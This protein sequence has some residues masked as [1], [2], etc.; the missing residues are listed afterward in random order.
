MKNI[1]SVTTKLLLAFCFIV[2]VFG[3]NQRNGDSLPNKSD[4]NVDFSNRKIIY[5][6]SYH[7][8]YVP[9]G[10]GRAEFEKIVS[11]HKIK[12]KYLYLDAK[13][14]KDTAALA[15][16][17]RAMRDIIQEWNPD[18]IVAADDAVNKY[19][20][21]RFFLNSKIPVVF[22]GVNWS[23]EKYGY[24][25]KNITGQIE[26]D[27]IERLIKELQQFSSGKRIGIL[28]G[29]TLT[30]KKNIKHYKNI[31]GITFDKEVLVDTFSQWEE[32]FYSLQKS[33]DILILRHSAG[34]VGW[35]Q[36]RAMEIVRAGTTIPT[37]SISHIMRDLVLFTLPKMNEEY[38]EYAAKTAIRIL[39]G[40]APKDIPLSKN[41]KSFRAI[42]MTL[43]EKLGI[44]FPVDALEDAHFITIPQKKI[45][46][47]NSYHTGY[48]WSD[49][50][51]KG[52]LKA[53]NLTPKT[54]K[55]YYSGGKIELKIVRMNTKMN[56]GIEFKKDAALKV[57][58]TINNWNPDIIISADDNAAKYVI[59]PY[60][61]DSKI[62]IIF[63]GLNWD[64]SVYGFPTDNIRGMVEV[65]PVKELIEFLKKYS[66][67][68]R[69]GYLIGDVL[70]ERK[71][72]Q[73]YKD[74]LGINFH[75]GRSAKTMEEWKRGFLELQDSVDMIVLQNVAGIHGWDSTAIDSFVKEKIKVP[76]GTTS[77]TVHYLSLV[78]FSRIGEEQG[79]WSGKQV[80][81]ILNGK[82]IS[83]VPLVFN[84]EFITYYNMPLAKKLNVKLPADMMDKAI[85]LNK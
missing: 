29:N 67:G 24:P 23:V 14:V 49:D 66:K 30:D 59:V 41:V 15:A 85:I 32:S 35:N 43:A 73:H 5:I 62:P 46:F 13:R 19:V 40:T 8:E 81:E 7:E 82:P 52:L 3:C 50:I 53:L 54:G 75:N 16:K 51:E 10:K 83:D 11:Y 64:A 37:G 72:L 33:V 74:V 71:E 69:L 6:D 60:F 84:K 68:D 48:D 58:D 44:T 1:I 70:S 63:C 12:T 65:A 4:K 42:N 17:G 47:I 28:T 2:S 76:V 39:K 22:N 38:G 36:S 79:W 9:N 20:I 31:L 56:P 80:I 57:K 18:L 26:V 25:T 55:E 21:S 45:L 78:S 77:G 27:Q 34:I 61:M